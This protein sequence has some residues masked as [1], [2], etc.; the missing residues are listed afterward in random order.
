MRKNY[1]NYPVEFV[2]NVFGESNAL[3]EVLKSTAGRDCPKLL[4]VA[5]ANV[6]QRTENLGVNIGR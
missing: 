2:Q 6:V 5:D 3:S 1:L 4:I